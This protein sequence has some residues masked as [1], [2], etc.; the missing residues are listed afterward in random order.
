VLRCDQS[1]ETRD[2]TGFPIPRP[3]MHT[4]GRTKL[5]ADGCRLTTDLFQMAT[6]PSGTSEFSACVTAVTVLP[7]S[8]NA[9]YVYDGDGVMV[10]SVVNGVTTYYAGAYQLEINGSDT[11]E[12]K[13]YSAAGMRIAMR[14]QVNGGDETLNWLIGDHLGSTSMTADADGVVVSEVKYSAFG[15][16]RYQD[17]VTPTD[18][19]YTGQRQEA[20][21]GLY[22]YVARWY[23]PAIG[24]FIQADTIIPDPGSAKGYDRFGYVANNPL[25]YTDP[26]GHDL[27]ESGICLDDPVYDSG[28]YVQLTPGGQRIKDV[29]IQYLHQPNLVGEDFTLEHF[30]GLIELYEM[31][32]AYDATDAMRRA[33]TV[34]LYGDPRAAYPNDTSML[35]RPYCIN[36]PCTANE[37]FNWMAVYTESAQRRW[38]N[39]VALGKSFKHLEDV[40]GGS[41]RYF[42][43]AWSIGN[44][45][46]HSSAED[47]VF[48][49]SSP[50]HW[51]N[52]PS[53][54][55]Q[56]LALGVEMGDAYDQIHYVQ[57][58][59]GFVVF[60]QG[61][62]NYWKWT[63]RLDGVMICVNDNPSGPCWRQE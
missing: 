55:K 57:A 24:R 8:V 47:K 19:L 63:E 39:V 56:L 33:W 10:K 13:Y 18:Y 37:V 20:E 46:L 9:T 40:P 2:I 12:R 44:S 48:T 52:Y 34:Q 21:L 22:Y 7:G 11:I 14:T 3:V 32:N 54:A 36:T 15:E 27:S 62:I 60:S 4:M 29:F 41:Q 61:Q 1:I 49:G 43:L 50:F 25:R 17:G 53:F 5:A 23:D 45:I 59:G 51:G 35:N 30:I 26:T 42:D 31:F 58:D 16:I 28:H 6:G 38:E